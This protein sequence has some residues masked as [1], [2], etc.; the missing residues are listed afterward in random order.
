MIPVGD[1]YLKVKFAF[2][3]LYLN[4]KI[5]KNFEDVSCILNIN[6]KIHT[7]KIIN[8][9]CSGGNLCLVSTVLNCS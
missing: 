2:G 8:I 9:G 1:L 6:D 7:I 3:I 5:L 4:L